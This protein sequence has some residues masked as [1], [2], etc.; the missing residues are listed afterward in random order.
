[1][2]LKNVG[3]FTIYSVPILLKIWLAHIVQFRDEAFLS[4]LFLGSKIT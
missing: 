1:M 4:S 3:N 2:F